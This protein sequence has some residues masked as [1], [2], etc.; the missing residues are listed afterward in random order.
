MLFHGRRNTSPSMYMNLDWR[1]SLLARAP[2]YLSLA[3][4]S[5]FGFPSQAVLDFPLDPRTLLGSFSGC[6]CTVSALSLFTDRDEC[7]VNNGG[8]EHSCKNTLGSF[9]C[10]CSPGYR[11]RHDGRSCQGGS[12]SII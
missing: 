8:C 10:C 5:F 6:I 2:L 9:M 3:P 4:C 12:Y 7:Q 1:T 11:L